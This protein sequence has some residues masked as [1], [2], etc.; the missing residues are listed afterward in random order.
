MHASHSVGLLCVLSAGNITAIV[1]ATTPTPGGNLITIYGTNMGNGSDVY[2]VTLA[3]VPV[4]AIVSQN[5]T[6]VVVLAAPAP[7]AVAGAA[8]V[9][10]AGFGVT[11]AAEVF[12][13]NVPPVA[14]ATLSPPVRLSF[15]LSV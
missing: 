3:G 9:Y 13:Y 2:N 10:A 1:P 15:C 14:G 5:R 8:I 12:R 6:H 4:A 11:V 7:A